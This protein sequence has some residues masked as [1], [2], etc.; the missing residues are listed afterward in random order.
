MNINLP[1]TGVREPPIPS[2]TTS[3]RFPVFGYCAIVIRDSTLRFRRHKF[4]PRIPSNVDLEIRMTMALSDDVC[5]L[6]MAN[7]MIQTLSVENW[8]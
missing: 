7:Q 6:T 2:S 8:Q 4:N 5:D 1:I 3:T